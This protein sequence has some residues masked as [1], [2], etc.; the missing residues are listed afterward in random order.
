MKKITIIERHPA[1]IKDGWLYRLPNGKQVVAS[2]GH[3]MGWVL[4]TLAEWRTQSTADYETE[5]KLILFQ[6]SETGWRIK[7][8]CRLNRT[9]V[10]DKIETV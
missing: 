6:G 1:E 2:S 4:Y 9:V 3:E 10:G 7:D 5:G 8:L